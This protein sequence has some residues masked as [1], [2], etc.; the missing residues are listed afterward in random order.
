MK[1]TVSGSEPA[2]VEQDDLVR[3]AHGF[4]QALQRFEGL[5]LLAE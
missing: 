2:V 5:T 4:L 3:H 1:S